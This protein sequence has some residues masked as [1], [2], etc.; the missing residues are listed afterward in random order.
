LPAADGVNE[1]LLLAAACFDGDHGPTHFDDCDVLAR[2]GIGDGAL[3]G[4]AV[5]W[6]ATASDRNGAHAPSKASAAAA[7]LAA[8][9]SRPAKPER[10]PSSSAAERVHALAIG[11][12]SGAHS[13]T[14][15]AAAATVSRRKP[16]GDRR[17]A[18]PAQTTALGMVPTPALSVAPDDRQPADGSCSELVAYMADSLLGADTS[19]AE[20]S[21]IA[22]DSAQ[23]AS[24]AAALD[25]G[26][27]PSEELSEEL[28]IGDSSQGLP[29]KQNGEKHRIVQYDLLVRR[30]PI[31]EADLH[32]CAMCI[33]DSNLLWFFYIL[34][35]VLLPHGLTIYS[36]RLHVWCGVHRTPLRCGCGAR[37]P[38]CRA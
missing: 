34:P 29:L 37:V 28:S 4:P 9:E 5:D 22:A 26:E 36:L 33:G 8:V 31:L 24:L 13:R 19:R 23:R 20:S 27:A 17:R 15:S 35:S 14:V 10:G 32:P 12:V 2:F 11:S 6:G 1:N 3:A 25:W 18:N 38:R 21:E 16:S 30:E 7:A